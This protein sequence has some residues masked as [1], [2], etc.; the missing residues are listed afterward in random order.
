M[1]PPSRIDPLEDLGLEPEKPLAYWGWGSMPDQYGREFDG[2][3]G[4]SSLGKDPGWMDL[5]PLHPHWGE[6]RRRGAE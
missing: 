3:D 6:S 4:E 2:D 1:E 5:P